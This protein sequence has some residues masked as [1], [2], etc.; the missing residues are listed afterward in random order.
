M[1]QASQHS[2]SDLIGLSDLVQRIPKIAKKLPHIVTGLRQAYLRKGETPT[3]LGWAFER[4]THKNPQGYAVYYED[5]KI[6]YAELNAWAN[7]LAHHF[8]S[9]GAKKVMLLR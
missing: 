9:I 8:V 5:Q 3:G 2:H 1:S 4:A 7:Q 6:T